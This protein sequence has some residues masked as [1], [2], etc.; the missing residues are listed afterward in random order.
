MSKEIGY[1]T[2]MTGSTTGAIGQILTARIVDSNVN[3]VEC[4][5][6]SSTDGYDEF[7]TTT[8]SAGQLNALIIYDSKYGGDGVGVANKLDTARKN[9]TVETWTLTAPS[10]STWAASGF[11]ASL[12]VAIEVKGVTIQPVIIKFTGKITFT[13]AET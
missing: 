2:T 6:C 10:A 5:N 9:K 13:P 11:I 4:T 3:F 7:I 12:G 8:L 1:G